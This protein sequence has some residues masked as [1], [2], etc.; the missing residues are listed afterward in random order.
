MFAADLL[1]SSDP[2]SR[3]VGLLALAFI[4]T[5]AVIAGAKAWGRGEGVLGF[6]TAASGA[7]MAIG[8]AN[9]VHLRLHV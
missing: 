6:I 7:H 8:Y 2:S 4:G 5:F 9:N 3:V 1:T